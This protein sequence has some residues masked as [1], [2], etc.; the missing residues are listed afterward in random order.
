MFWCDCTCVCARPAGALTL[1][2]LHGNRGRLQ[3]QHLPVGLRDVDPEHHAD[4]RVLASDI[5][6]ALPQL[7][8]GVP[9]LE[10]AGAVDTARAEGGTGV[11]QMAP[12]APLGRKSLRH[13]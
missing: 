8:V 13:A 9:Q 10:D 2:A 3:R 4:S 1:T 12:Y 7:D 11:E 5:R 6:L